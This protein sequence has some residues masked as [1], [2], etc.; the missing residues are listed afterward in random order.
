VAGRG[1][2]AAGGEATDFGNPR[3]GYT[4]DPEPSAEAAD[5]AA[6][7]AAMTTAEAATTR[8]RCDAC[9]R[10]LLTLTWP[11]PLDAVP[12]SRRSGRRLMSGT[13]SSSTAAVATPV[14]NSGR[15]F[16]SLVSFDFAT[17]GTAASGWSWRLWRRLHRR[18]RR[19]SWRLWRRPHRRLRR[20]PHWKFRRPRRR[21]QWAH[22]RNGVCG[23]RRRTGS[24]LDPEGPSLIVT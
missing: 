17:G 22:W 1:S 13:A 4:C 10:N 5:V 18:L 24:P 21:L 19:R 20:W 8:V 2:R 16:P 3:V 9:G 15:T 7:K 6:A 11:C 12:A 23:P 14:F